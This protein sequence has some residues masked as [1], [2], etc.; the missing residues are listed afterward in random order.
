MN[1]NLFRNQ[2]PK[3]SSMST[4]ISAPQPV[5]DKYGREQVWLKKFTLPAR[6]FIYVVGN[7]G[8]R[9]EEIRKG[10]NTQIKYGPEQDGQRLIQV[11]GTSEQID[12]LGANVS[13]LS[14]FLQARKIINKILIFCTWKA[15]CL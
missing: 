2:R 6:Y 15:H 14:Q 11:T 10:T 8:A 7:A 1:E 13:Y 9:I 4:Q 12:R 5:R 3:E